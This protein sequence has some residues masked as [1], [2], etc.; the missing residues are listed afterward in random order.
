MSNFSR[1][2]MVEGGGEVTVMYS[3]T[4]LSVSLLMKTGVRPEPL[5]R[6]CNIKSSKLILSRRTMQSMKNLKVCLVGINEMDTYD[7][8]FGW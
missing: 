8:L 3:P 2:K 7:P 6:C 4:Q 5:I 1:P